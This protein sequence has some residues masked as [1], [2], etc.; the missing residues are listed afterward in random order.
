[1]KKHIIIFAALALLSSSI[2]S[3]QTL[4]LI[5]FCNTLLSEDFGIERDY[6]RIV[7]EASMVASLIGYN[8]DY[9]I[10][11]GENCSNERLTEVL[12][13]LNCGKDDIIIFYYSGHGGRSPKDQSEFPQMCLKYSPINQ[14]KF[15]A[16]HTVVERLREKNARFTLVLTD[17]CNSTASGISV[18]SLLDDMTNAVELTDA[19]VGRYKK[20]FVESK[21]IVVA[22]SSKKGQTSSGS[23]KGG[24]FSRALL[25]VALPQAINGNIPATWA[26]VLQQT[27]SVISSRQEPYWE[28]SLQPATVA[29]PTVEPQQAITAVD[30]SFAKEL[31]DL[32]DKSRSV[33]WRLE[34]ADW[35]AKKYFADDAK[36]ATVGR[37]GSTV[38]EYELARDFLRR[39]ASSTFVKQV[40]I[41]KE[42]TN[43][44]GK[45]NYLKVQEIRIK[46]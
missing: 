34:Q 29:T 13:T 46:K 15:V 33:D 37:N 40:N 21:G 17:C 14:D 26:D 8:I 45:R 36:V 28:I 27:S 44:Q 25:E 35:L 5:N 24:L 10:G 38:I 23:P 2:L 20:L 9:Y 43:Q 6:D 32:L 1:M 4:H 41:I 22:T 16:V 18:K 42:S 11:D 12:N 3:A 7:N 31:S 39:I 19:E 30:N